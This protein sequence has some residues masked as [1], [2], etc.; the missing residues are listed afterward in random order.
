[1]R[2]SEADIFT[3]NLDSKEI[4]NLTKDKFANYAPTWATDGRS[5][6]Y[7]VR[8]SGNEKLF[9]MDANGTNPV[10]LTFGTHD[11]GGAQFLDANTLLFASTAVNPASRSSRT[12]RRT[13][14]STTSGRST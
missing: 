12:S 9:R 13:G 5:I 7:L 3:V 10:Q 14:R 6:V 8:V 11:D 2:D 1:M 4:V